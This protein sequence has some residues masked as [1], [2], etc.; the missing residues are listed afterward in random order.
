MIHRFLESLDRN[1][2]IES[3]SE[4]TK[5]IIWGFLIVIFVIILSGFLYGFA[6]GIDQW[7]VQKWGL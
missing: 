5:T 7:M 4:C 1:T 2:D 3:D 6:D